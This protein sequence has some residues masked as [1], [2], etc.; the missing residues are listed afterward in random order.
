[1]QAKA[2]SRPL[3]I[4][5]GLSFMRTPIRFEHKRKSVLVAASGFSLSGNAFNSHTESK[6]LVA[7]TREYRTQSPVPSVLYTYLPLAIG[8]QDPRCCEHML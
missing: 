1:M 6:G 4:F 2:I 3:T 8:G 5:R 7:Q